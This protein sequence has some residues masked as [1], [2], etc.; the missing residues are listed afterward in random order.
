[1]KHMLIAIVVVTITLVPLTNAL[2]IGQA[3][4]TPKSSGV[5]RPAAPEAFAVGV[6]EGADPGNP[7][8]LILKVTDASDNVR[9]LEV[10]GS[11]KIEFP[12]E[13]ARKVSMLK[14]GERVR[15]TGVIKNGKF[16]VR[17][18]LLRAN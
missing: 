8:V 3:T 2:A 5:S 17:G 1:M 14:P 6:V 7:A 12:P 16:F 4:P 9:P 10:N 15:V 11:L 18:V 13:Y